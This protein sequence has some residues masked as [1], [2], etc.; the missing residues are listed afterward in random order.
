VQN[1][2]DLSKATSDLSPV[3]LMQQ[4][5]IDELPATATSKA[6][7]S[8]PAKVNAHGT[9]GGGKDN[10]GE[11]LTIT[12][13]A[14]ANANGT[15][16]FFDYN[17]RSTGFEARVDV[18]CLYVADDGK[19]A[20]ISG[21]VSDL[22]LGDSVFPAVEGQL[23]RMTFEDGGEGKN[24]DDFTSLFFFLITQDGDPITEVRPDF[25][26]GVPYETPFI[27]EKGQVQVH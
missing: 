10:P 8:K 12:L 14:V 18:N 9:Y 3:T 11:Q 5:S 17:A 2:P 22:D 26:Q 6:K 25:C 1:A 23:V 19:T 24:A 4:M 15:T 7:S 27:V 20:T 21:N 16:G 13:N